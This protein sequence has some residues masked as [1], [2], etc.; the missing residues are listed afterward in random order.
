MENGLALDVF[1]VTA[2]PNVGVLKAEAFG[3]SDD[4]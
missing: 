2:A 3:S 4:V 1:D